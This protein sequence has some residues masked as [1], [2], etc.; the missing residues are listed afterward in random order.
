MEAGQRLDGADQLHVGLGV[1]VAVGGAGVGSGEVAHAF[2]LPDEL[3]QRATGQLRVALL[4][5]VSL[6]AQEELRAG[7]VLVQ[8]LLAHVQPADRLVALPHVEEAAALPVG[9]ALL[10]QRRQLQRSLQVERIAGRLVGVEQGEGGEHLVAEEAEDVGRAVVVAIHPLA[11]LAD[12]LPEEVE[13]AQGA[14]EQLRLVQRPR[15]LQVGGGGHGV[16]TGI[17]GAVD[18]GGRKACA[19][20]GV[21]GVELLVGVLAAEEGAAVRVAQPGVQVVDDAPCGL[22]VLLIAGGVEEAKEV[23]EQVGVVLQHLLEVGHAP[24]AIG[25]VAEEAAPDVVEYAP[26]GHLLQRLARHVEQVR[27]VAAQVGVE[28]QVNAL[29]VGELGL[30]AKA[31][32]D[33]VV[34]VVDGGE[35]VLEDLVGGRAPA[36]RLGRCLAVP[37]A[38]LLYLLADLLP[39]LPVVG[40]E[41]L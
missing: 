26:A 7:G 38:R 2:L 22:G 19:G 24:V 15:G 40:A 1:Q 31:A 6:Q 3:P 33:G 25:G 39:V 16:P 23:A 20:V 4:S 13:G 17:D 37:L 11:G 5:G 21:Q 28:E 34:H 36:A 27:V 41:L 9:E 18:V 12:A 32:V 30:A 8:R 14:V 10:Q 29:R 35:D